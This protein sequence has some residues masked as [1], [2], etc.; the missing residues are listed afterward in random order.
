MSDLP[1]GEAEIRAA[2]ALALASELLR[3]LTAKGALG[4]D[5]AQGI[6]DRAAL[7]AETFA[8]MRA[9]PVMDHLTA[10][11]NLLRGLPRP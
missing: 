4:V 1:A 3:E 7:M 5:D 9:A 2:A 6:T 11:L 10:A 8:G